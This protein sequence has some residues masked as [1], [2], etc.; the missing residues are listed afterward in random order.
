MEMRRS[1]GMPFTA[2]EAGPVLTALHAGI[3]FALGRW[4]APLLPVG[5]DSG[6]A[7]VWEQ[8]RPS[9]CDPGRAPGIGWWYERDDAALAD[10]LKLLITAFADPARRER[11]WMQM[12]LAISATSAPG[13]IEQRIM[14]GFSGL[15]HLMWQNLVLAGKRTED[16]YTR[17]P[18]TCSAMCSGRR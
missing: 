5:L 2:R 15:E 8:W 6:G 11:L 16:G 18:P 3:S 7:A 9:F 14:V 12:V 4:V 17:G 13:F 10:F 1:D